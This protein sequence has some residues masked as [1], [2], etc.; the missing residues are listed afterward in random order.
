MTASGYIAMRWYQHIV[1]GV[2]WATS[3]KYRL[4]SV[5]PT[6][7]AAASPVATGTKASS[8]SAAAV[9]RRAATRQAARATVKAST[10]TA[11]RAQNSW[12]ERVDMAAGLLVGGCRVVVPKKLTLGLALV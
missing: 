3:E 1:H 6:A 8:A 10:A 12:T 7:I 11:S 2:E 5:Q 4:P 9:D